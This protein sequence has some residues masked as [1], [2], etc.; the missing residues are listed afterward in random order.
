MM[1]HGETER[2]RVQIQKVLDDASTQEQRNEMGQFATPP[3]LAIQILRHASERSTDLERVRFLDPGIGTGALYSALLSTVPRERIASSDGYEI[4]PEIA[5]AAKRLWANKGLN[6]QREDFTTVDP[7]KHDSRFNLLI[8]NP[9]YVR[10]HHIGAA[11]KLQMKQRLESQGHMKLNGLAGL[12]AYFIGL[13]HPWMEP[14][15]LASWLIPSEFMDVNF[16]KGVRDYLTNKVSLM[17]IHRFDPGESQ[18]SDA[19]VSSAAVWFTNTTPQSGHRVRM[20]FGGNAG[21]ASNRHL[22]PS[23]GAP[24]RAQVVA[25][26]GG[27]SS[28]RTKPC[29]SSRSVQHKTGYR[30]RKERF[31][32]RIRTGGQTEKPAQMGIETGSARGQEVENRRG[33]RR[34]ARATRTGRT[35]VPPGLRPR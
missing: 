8:C 1:R 28:A 30:H 20:T 9:P 2:R 12:Y 18:F 4:Q 10:H 19:L 34:P 29:Y 16:G 22:H 31:L 23:G 35:A 32:R 3:E 17:H 5:A 14:G 6:V 26:P 11:R 21:S 7:P 27:Y 15:A 24:R 13:T 25:L 33:R